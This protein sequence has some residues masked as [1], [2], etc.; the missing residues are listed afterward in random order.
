MNYQ[1][2]H[3]IAMGDHGIRRVVISMKCDES[4]FLWNA[5]MHQSIECDESL[6]TTMEYNGL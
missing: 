2:L 5:M 6:W 4:L 3:W 1:G